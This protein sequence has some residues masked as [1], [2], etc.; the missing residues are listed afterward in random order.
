MV[1]TKQFIIVKNELPV[2][3]DLCF[4]FGGATDCLETK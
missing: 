1:N 4:Y 3:R 2:K